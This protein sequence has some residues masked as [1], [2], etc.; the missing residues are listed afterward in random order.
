MLVI[1]RGIVCPNMKRTLIESDS[2]GA[3]NVL[4]LADS[5]L[6]LVLEN[7]PNMIGSAI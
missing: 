6:G 3:R 7:S 5:Q 4:F 1:L 2:Q